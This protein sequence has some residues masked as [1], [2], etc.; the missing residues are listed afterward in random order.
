[1]YIYTSLLT[2]TCQNFDL[3]PWDTLYISTYLTTH[4]LGLENSPVAQ[5]PKNF[6]TFNGTQEVP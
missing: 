5:P 3:F 1:M 6:P 2:M 4:S